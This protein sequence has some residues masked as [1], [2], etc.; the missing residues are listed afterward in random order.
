MGGL[1]LSG[2]GEIFLVIVLVFALLIS[3]GLAVGWAIHVGRYRSRQTELTISNTM[4]QQRAERLAEEYDTLKARA[5]E[6]LDELMGTNATL[7]GTNE[8]LSADIGGLRE[9]LE[10]ITSENVALIHQLRQLHED[11][12]KQSAQ[13]RKNISELTQTVVSLTADL[14][15]ANARLDE[16]MAGLRTKT[17]EAADLAVKV[18]SLVEMVA[19]FRVM[20]GL[21]IEPNAPAVANP[22][23]VIDANSLPA[24]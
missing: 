7:A 9:T 14:K 3:C 21:A 22:A 16:L 18:N 2:K 12:Q 6:A 13:S 8:A 15:A 4:L 23:P 20:T 11:S 24:G 1:T 10:T 5:E 19:R 17:Q